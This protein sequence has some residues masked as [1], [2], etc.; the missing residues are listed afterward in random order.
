MMIKKSLY[1]ISI[2]GAAGAA[3]AGVRKF[4][5]WQEASF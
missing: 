3:S 4:M 1:V 5:I 2:Y